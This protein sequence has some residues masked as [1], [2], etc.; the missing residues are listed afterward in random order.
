MQYLNK[1]IREKLEARYKHLD[2]MQFCWQ[3]PGEPFIVGR[4]TREV[5]RI[6]DGAITDYKN[7]KSSFIIVKIPFRHGKSDIVSRYLPPHFLG[8]FPDNEV[9]IVTYASSRAEGFSAFSRGL[10]RSDEYKALYPD[11]AVSKE[12]AGVQKWGIAGKLGSCVASGLSSGIT[13]K[14]YHLGILDDYCAGRTE[15]ESAVMRDNAWEHFTND[16]LTRRAPV[17]ITIILATPWHV[18]D[19]I[20]RIEKRIDKNSDTYDPEFPPFRVVSFPA[21]NGTADVYNAEKKISERV[22][23]DYLFP[24]RF[25]ADWYKQQ[26][27]SLGSYGTACSVIR[28]CGAAIC[29]RCNMLKNIQA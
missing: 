18:D 14:G 17:S 15:A 20:G 9:M 7:G 2:F 21:M 4:H 5:C 26:A 3:K 6:I 11:I 16:F 12:A 24:E 8:E 10:V 25:S 1:S 23:Y 13:G 19:I 27:A 29:L 22:S 28:R